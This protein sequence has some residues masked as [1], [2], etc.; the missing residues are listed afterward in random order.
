M[1]R[2]KQFTHP[3]DEVLLEAHLSRKSRILDFGCGYGRTV[4]QLLGSGYT[5]VQGYDTSKE[6][7]ARGARE[8]GLSL[9]HI[10]APSELLVPDASVDCVLLFAVLT[11]IP[12]NTEQRA[13]LDILRAKL[14]PNGLLYISDYYL[15]RGGPEAHR[16]HTLDGDPMN[17]GVFHLDEGV[18]F[19][20]HMREWIAE[21]LQG[22][23]ILSERS[24]EVLTMNGHA[25]EAFQVLARK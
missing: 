10:D 25:A 8:H 21:L 12:S 6:L 1:A 23:T 2:T 16:Y 19:R 17:H 15:Q 7:V 9:V 14:K 20:H 3:L 13:L 24:I 11:C 5:D 18:T 22:L 4:K